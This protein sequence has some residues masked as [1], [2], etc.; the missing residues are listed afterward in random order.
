[1]SKIMF[2]RASAK[3]IF[4]LFILPFLILTNYKCG[5]QKKPHV[6][7]GFIDLSGHDFKNGKNVRL[8]GPWE[9]YW[10]DFVFERDINA[11]DPPQK[12]GYLN[13]FESWKNFLIDG[14]EI[15]NDGYASFRLEVGVSDEARILCLY[16][17]SLTVPFVVYINNEIL[18]KNGEAGKTKENSKPQRTSM[19]QC[20]NA[21][22]NKFSI[23]LHVS[24]FHHLLS[25]PRM[26]LYMG[27]VNSISKMHSL[28]QGLDLFVIGGFLMMF[29]Y[30]L[31]LYFLRK[32]DKS[33]FYFG[34]FCGLILLRSLVMGEAVL[35]AVFS[36][37]S[38]ELI[39][40]IEYFTFFAFPAV[41]LSFFKKLFPEEIPR[42]FSK[43]INVIFFVSLPFLIF[44]AKI[45]TILLVPYQY[46]YLLGGPFCIYFLMK[47]LIKKR[48]GSNIIIW[49]FIVLFITVINDILHTNEVIDTFQL[50][51]LGSLA[52]IFFQAYLLSKKFVGAF[53]ESEELNISLAEVTDELIEKSKRLKDAYDENKKYL[54]IEK[55]LE[56]S[57]LV[58]KNILID[59]KTLDGIKEF[60]ID[61]QYLPMN[62]KVGGDYYHIDHPRQNRLSITL[63][64]AIGH[65]ILAALSTMRIDIM[66]KQASLDLNPHERFSLM[67]RFIYEKKFTSEAWF[68]AFICDYNEGT[69]SY[70]SAG[71]PHQI[72]LKKESGPVLLKAKGTLIGVDNK[73]EYETKE[74]KFD[75][76]DIL[77]LF[78][79]GIYEEID[80]DNNEYGEKKFNEFIKKNAEKFLSAKSSAQIS[81]VIIDELES[82]RAKKFSNDDICLIVV[83]LAQ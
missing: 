35:T 2:N 20:F 64:D 47:A 27:D 46:I 80:H 5:N 12:S 48:E 17:N 14:K 52:F 10:N 8:S 77:I 16:A 51:G 67:N 59:K 9:F 60:D 15:E 57:S 69:L 25:G 1:M 50:T 6:Q 45:Y 21:P 28:L 65:G 78:T 26:N 70:A 3:R 41:I 19:T 55:E 76:E 4:I 7:N 83:R 40:K 23:I 31:G 38:W 74:I 18:L 36:N 81:G 33:I 79:D 37:L 63:A 56:I 61:V 29:I 54:E 68:S 58:Q 62:Q 32:K 42:L 75:K 73:S 66:S 82:Y 39:M 43:I 30:H 34:V 11:E 44:E 24:S 53:E 13:I 22:Q 71:H 72:L 49:G